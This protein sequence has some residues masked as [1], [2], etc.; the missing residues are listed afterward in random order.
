MQPCRLQCWN[1]WPNI[2]AQKLHQDDA[3]DCDRHGYGADDSHSVAFF[4]DEGKGGE[5]PDETQQHFVEAGEWGMT[6]L[7][8][9]VRHG[10]CVSYEAGPCRYRS[11]FDVRLSPG[12]AEA[13]IEGARTCVEDQRRV[14]QV[15]FTYDVSA[16][17]YV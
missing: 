1:E 11:K 16:L 7:V 14:E 4:G 15:G 5:G 2:T 12:D 3:D 10:C 13:E 6:G 9:A 8:P 17:H